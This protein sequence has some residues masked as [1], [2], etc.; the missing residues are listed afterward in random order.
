MKEFLE[1]A[2]LAYY[3]G[4]PI[5][6]D[7][8]FDYLAEKYNFKNVGYTITDG[9]PHLFPMFSLS[10]IFDLKDA[11][12]PL[13]FKTVNSPKLDGAAVSLLYIKGELRLA[14]TRGDGKIGAD[15]T[16]K[17]RTL[18]PN[19]I[20][21]QNTIQITGEVVAPKDIENSRNFASGSLGL[22]SLEEFK[23]RPLAF[24]AYD[25][26]PNINTSW[27]EEMTMLMVNGFK[28]VVFGNYHMYPTDGI[29]YR[30]DNYK[31]FLDCGFT[32]HHPKGA[33]ALKEK[34]EGE[35]TTLVGVE[36]Q[37]GKSG[38]VSPV[39]ILDPVV[40]DGARISKATLHNIKYI[41]SLNLEIGCQVE[42]IRS[43]EIIPRVVRRVE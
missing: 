7:E 12:F 26:C 33:F 10:K 32:S 20:E 36:W 40:I 17:M 29:V 1:E 14:L 35:I 2:S 3:S 11:P 38:V 30:I 4:A 41:E 27:T 23:T 21:L 19:K 42:V 28:T 25:S 22:K 37:V 9:V 43:G 18:V 13:N 6:S 8:E 39:A 34:K 24:I 15:I 16:D 31:D 5:I